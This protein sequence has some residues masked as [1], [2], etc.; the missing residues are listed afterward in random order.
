MA[1]AEESHADANSRRRAPYDAI[2][3][4]DFPLGTLPVIGKSGVLRAELFNQLKSE[5]SAFISM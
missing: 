4:C 2:G 3:H 1:S 5:A